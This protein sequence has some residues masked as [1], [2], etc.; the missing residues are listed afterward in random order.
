MKYLFST[1]I[2]MICSVSL[3]TA[4]SDAI[5]KYFDKYMDD[6]R[7]TMVFVS[8]KMFQ[9]LDR[10]A[11]EDVNDPDADVVLD[12]AKDLRGLRILTT[13]Q[14]PQKFYNEFKA[15]FDKSSYEPLMLVRDKGQDVNFLIDED[16][17]H[18]KELL[19]L[20]GGKEEF[21]LLSFVGNIHLDK[22]SKLSNQISLPG[23]EHL[24]KLED[25]N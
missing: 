23:G 13:D 20:V 10:L 17:D 11:P 6:E 3:M 5:S 2:A 19:M 9:M 12:V 25:K 7:F 16:G 4:Q 24:D 14:E 8:P 18:V 22:L 1:L 15:V 21:V